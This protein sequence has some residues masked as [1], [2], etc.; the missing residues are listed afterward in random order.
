MLIFGLEYFSII[1][2]KVWKAGM[3]V[4]CNQIVLMVISRKIEKI[5]PTTQTS[6]ETFALGFSIATPFFGI[7]ILTD[8]ILINS[9][10]FIA[11]L[12]IWFF[13]FAYSKKASEEFRS[14]KIK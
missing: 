11:I 10:M 5:C 6:N 13:L 1:P 7:G 4:I 9:I 8:S 2:S 14:Q 3:I 12:F